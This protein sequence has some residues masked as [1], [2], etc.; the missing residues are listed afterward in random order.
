MGI[1]LDPS[2]RVLDDNHQIFVLHPGQGKRF[3]SD[4]IANEAVFLD[5]PGIKFN[6]VPNID[7]EHVRSSLRMSRAISGWYRKGKPEDKKPSRNPSDYIAKTENL[8]AS[9]FMTE[10][11]ELYTTAKTGDLVI[12]P[13]QGYNTQVYIGEFI[14]PLDADY[15]ITSERYPFEPIPARKVKFLK[16]NLAKWQFGARLVRLMQNRQAIIKITQD[17]DVRDVYEKAYGNYVWGD[18]S[19]SMLLIFMNSIKHLR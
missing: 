7:S 5:V 8:P 6:E 16:T 11:K 1:I 4:F 15:T 3:Y 13:G 9:R 12:I 19:G 17:D 18:T 14:G 2:V 10:V